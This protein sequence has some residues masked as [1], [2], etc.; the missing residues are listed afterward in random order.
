MNPIE[1][2]H[3]RPVLLSVLCI[4]TYIS[5]GFGALSVL[6]GLISGPPTPDEIAATEN[7]ML[8]S[9]NMLREQGAGTAAGLMEQM[10]VMFS[11]GN[12]KFWLV[13]AINAISVT[14]GILGAAFMWRGRKTGFH[15]YIIYN[16]LSILTVYVSVPIEHV[17]AY[18]TITNVILSL[19]FIL[20]YSRNLKWMK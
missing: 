10:S 9:I 15:L 4:L 5:C 7:A 13:L 19:I 3:D 1:K 20:L 6:L 14:L 17:P 8:E 16:I 11:Y 18:L 12:D 2:R